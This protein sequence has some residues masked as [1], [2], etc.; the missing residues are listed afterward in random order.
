MQLLDLHPTEPEKEDANNSGS[1]RLEI[2]EAG[3]GHGALTL[4]L[5]RAIHGANVPHT[6]LLH[7]TDDSVVVRERFRKARRA[8][9]HTIDI[10]SQYVKHAQKVV[11]GFRR[12]LYFDDVDFHIGDVSEFIESRLSENPEPYLSAA[13]LDMPSAENHLH[14]VSKA[15]RVDGKLAVFNPSV[16][17]IGDC[18]RRIKKEKLP[19][20]LDTVV[21]LGMG[22]SGGRE[23]DVRV[24]RVRAKQASPPTSSGNGAERTKQSVA[25]DNVEE[26]NDWKD[27]EPPSQS[28]E[29]YKG[30]QHNDEGYR[31][32]ETD[33][34]E[35]PSDPARES[36]I[37][38]S[39]GDSSQGWAMV[40]RPK[41]GK[42]VVGG[43]FVGLWSK[44]RE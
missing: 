33:V 14:A 5:A 17:Q 10:K 9:I 39:V 15:L 12:G 24:A 29:P 18:V 4:H 3:T 22:I 11:L 13:V 2:L 7:E 40:C 32:E 25:V 21:E 37:L 38:Q 20:S 28:T 36:P 31:S 30:E 44:I 43:G 8:V 42:M 41:V 16:T 35:A 26:H 6:S 1:P 23:W 34:S 19:L 27:A